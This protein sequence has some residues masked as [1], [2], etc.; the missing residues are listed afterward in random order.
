MAVEPE[1]I[2]LEEYNKRVTEWGSKLGNKIRASIRSLTSKGKG[3][4]VKS[5]RL[6]A[7]K[8]YGEVDLLTYQF[9]RHGVFV[10][11]GVGRG[12]HM[13]GGRVVRGDKPGKVLTALTVNQKLHQVVLKSARV[14]RKPAEWFNP[15]VAENI[16]GLANLIA[17]MDADRMVNATK[18]MIK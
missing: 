13:E 3:D 10:H 1:E 8:W 4:L 12:Y 6:K 18:M 14:N 15:V 16:E 2:G 11:K 9:D 7:K 5:L 17:E